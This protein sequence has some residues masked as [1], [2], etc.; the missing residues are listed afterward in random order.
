MP[1][2]MTWTPTPRT[3]PRLLR[4]FAFE[5][6]A[7][8]AMTDE[9]RRAFAFE[10]AMHAA[11]GRTVTAAWGQA[12]LDPALGR[13]HE[14]NFVTAVAD[15][16]EHDAATL[17]AA[18]E[19]LLGGEDL[20]H[21]RITVEGD[22]ADARVR[23]ELLA[24][25]YEPSRHVFL[26]FP[27]SA[28]PPPSVPGVTVVETDADAVVEANAHYLRTDPDTGYGRDDQTR[29]ELV[30]HHRTYAA[31]GPATER[32]FVVQDDDDGVVAWARLWTAGAVAQVEDVVCLAEHRGH[33]YGR[34]VVTEATRAALAGGAELTFIVADDADWPKELYGRLGY[35]PI[36]HLGVYLRLVP[37]RG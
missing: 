29:A 37:A 21:R 17:D 23:G 14:R 30:E 3:D 7:L 32:V 31:L 20:L 8:S 2:P 26:A 24:L 18:A 28:G 6:A 12:F 4:A 9:L 34:A 27:D 11:A 22:D 13:C 15:A 35:E 1:P 5:R 16:G 10:R 36:G 33:G 19:R 25:G